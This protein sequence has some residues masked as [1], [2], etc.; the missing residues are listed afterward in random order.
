[1]ILCESEI[2]VSHESF[3][4]VVDFTLICLAKKVAGV[5]KQRQILEAQIKRVYICITG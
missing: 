3:I 2:L 1:M 5:P 4:S